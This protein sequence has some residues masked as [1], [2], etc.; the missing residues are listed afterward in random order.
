MIV[1][2]LLLSPGVAVSGLS[3]I[4]HSSGNC[5][6]VSRE[7]GVVGGEDAERG[8]DIGTENG[9]EFWGREE[10]EDEPDSAEP[11]SS[12]DTAKDSFS[13]AERI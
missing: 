8:I 3:V 10:Y 13:K 11:S 2:W 4:C 6:K 1:M 9:A 12:P 5:G 7:R